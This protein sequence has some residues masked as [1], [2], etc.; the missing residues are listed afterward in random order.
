MCIYDVYSINAI[1][2]MRYTLYYVDA[3]C[4][5]F[6]I[7]LLPIDPYSP[8]LSFSSIPLHTLIKLEI[9]AYGCKEKRVRIVTENGNNLS[10]IG[11]LVCICILCVCVYTVCLYVCS[12]AS[13][14]TTEYI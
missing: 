12:T 5:V 8:A 7:L 14:N 6:C 9:N 4:Y 13:Y 1:I 11:M 3:V 2:C 10:A